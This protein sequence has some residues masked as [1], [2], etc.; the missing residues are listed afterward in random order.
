MK[1][2]ISFPRKSARS[3][4]INFCARHLVFVAR[5][6]LSEHQD[7]LYQPIVARDIGTLQQ[8]VAERIL[9]PKEELS[10]LEEYMLFIAGFYKS[11][12]FSS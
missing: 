11:F 7:A 4:W 9:N 5:S 6:S 8:Q 12:R 10:L 3:T 1:Y 2:I